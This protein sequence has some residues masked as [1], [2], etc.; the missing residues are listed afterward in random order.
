[1]KMDYFKTDISKKDFKLLHK[2]F[3][4]LCQNVDRVEIF[5]PSG[6]KKFC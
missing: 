1:M 2:K 6:I 4:Q 5:L 3:Y